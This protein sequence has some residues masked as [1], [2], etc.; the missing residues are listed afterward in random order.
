[1]TIRGFFSETRLV[2]G[3]PALLS[4]VPYIRTF[5]ELLPFGALD[6][7]VFLVDTGADMTVINPQDGLRLVPPEAWSRL[8]SP[9]RLGG[10][11]ARM[12]HLPIEAQISFTHDNGR[13]EAIT[14]TVYVATA[15][16]ANIRLESLLG[17]DVLTNFVMSFDQ[18]GRQLT[19]A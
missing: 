3:N 15:G 17:R 8:T 1:M 18:S 10:A 6:E 13:V 14:T 5:V 9:L 2:S 11:G 19:L 7:V 4:A 16:A 12:D